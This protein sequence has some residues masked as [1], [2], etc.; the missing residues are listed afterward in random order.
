MDTWSQ[1]G[2]ARWKRAQRGWSIRLALA[3]LFIMLGAG[4]RLHAQG[5]MPKVSQEGMIAEAEWVVVADLVAKCRS[6][7]RTAT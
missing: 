3:A 2:Y 5:L 7:M 4:S 6:A 1:A